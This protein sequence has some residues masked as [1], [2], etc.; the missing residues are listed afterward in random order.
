MHVKGDDAERRLAKL[1]QRMA[2]HRARENGKKKVPA[3]DKHYWFASF[4]KHLGF[5][6]SNFKLSTSSFT[7]HPC[8]TKAHA[9]LHV[10][11]RTLT[12][13][14]TRGFWVNLHLVYIL[15][16]YI[17]HYILPMS[18]FGGHRYRKL[19]GMFIPVVPARL[20]YN[21]FSPHPPLYYT[22]YFQCL[23]LVATDI[24]GMLIPVVFSC[25]SFRARQHPPCSQ[26]GQCCSI[27]SHHASQE[28]ALAW[29]FHSIPWL[30]QRCWLSLQPHPWWSPQSL[31]DIHK[32]WAFEF[33]TTITPNS[34]TL[35][36]VAWTCAHTDLH[37]LLSVHTCTHQHYHYLG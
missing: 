27:C 6:L 23:S 31:L 30:S 35:Q 5:L 17:L 11:V 24:A 9:A 37:I 14:A 1:R 21:T 26:S 20:V 33:I 28:S 3:S 22:I 12:Q 25:N 8:V 2:N 13:L 32:H 34:N 19:A 10:H 4:G 29:E 36:N 16:H 18:V 7:H 15:S